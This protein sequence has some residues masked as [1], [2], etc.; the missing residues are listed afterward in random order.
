METLKEKIKRF[1]KEQVLLKDQRKSVYNKLER[2]ISPYNAQGKHMNN[3][4]ALR[5]MYS[6][7]GLLRGKSLEEVKVIYG[8]KY[9]LPYED[10]NHYLPR[11]NK[12]VEQHK[13][14]FVKDEETIHT[15][16]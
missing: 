14:E 10:F 12:V 6:A 13:E 16:K 11:I 4:Q 3:R 7:L 1:N 9:D 5:E 15:D 2:T 8:G